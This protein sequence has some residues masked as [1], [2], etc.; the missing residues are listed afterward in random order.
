[1]L[2]TAAIVD[3]GTTV[4]VSVVSRVASSSPQL[5]AVSEV[6]QRTQKAQANLMG[7]PKRSDCTAGIRS[8]SEGTRCSLG[9]A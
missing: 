6:S 7:D 2:I 8:A 4:Q 9:N 5:M 3:N 1:M